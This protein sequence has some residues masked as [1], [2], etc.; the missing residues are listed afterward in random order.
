M[1]GVAHAQGEEL[2]CRQSS[3]RTE[4]QGLSYVRRGVAMFAN[5]E[6]ATLIFR[7]ESRPPKARRQDFS[8]LMLMRFEDGATF[9][10][11]MQGVMQFGPAGIPPTM[12]ASGK[13]VEGT[14]RF[15]GISGTIEFKGRDMDIMADGNLGDIFGTGR[16]TYTLNRQQ[17]AARLEGFE[18]SAWPLT[19]F[20]A[21]TELRAV[22]CGRWVAVKSNR[23]LHVT[24]NETRQTCHRTIRQVWRSVPR[25][26]S[27]SR[28]ILPS[29]SEPAGFLFSPTMLSATP[30]SSLVA[31]ARVEGLLRH[32]NGEHISQSQSDHAKHQRRR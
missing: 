16:A 29:L 24:Q 8:G 20:I 21:P 3:I 6:P 13:L 4:M 12:S 22:I 19:H 11:D 31:R 18:Q 10:F 26:A 14:G 5:G 9:S 1:T 23:Q 15:A 27:A 17:Q 28:R 7:G 30:L 2:S 32:L 25:P